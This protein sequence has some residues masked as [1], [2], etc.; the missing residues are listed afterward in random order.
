[1]PFDFSDSV[2]AFHLAD[3]QC[4][5]NHLQHS[6]EGTGGSPKRKRNNGWVFEQ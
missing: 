6:A 3:R 4:I 1:M 5:E 2:P